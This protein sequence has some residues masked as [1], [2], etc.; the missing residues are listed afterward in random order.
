[1]IMMAKPSEFEG[2]A[3]RDHEKVAVE[4]GPRRLKANSL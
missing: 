4:A 2:F 1:M 3:H